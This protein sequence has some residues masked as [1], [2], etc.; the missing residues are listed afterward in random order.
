[1]VNFFLN[2]LDM[3]NLIGKR[4]DWSTILGEDN[5]EFIFSSK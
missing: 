5:V 1:M 2:I 3:N 4:C